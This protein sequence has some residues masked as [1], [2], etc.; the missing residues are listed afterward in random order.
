MDSYETILFDKN[1]IWYVH[2]IPFPTQQN[3]Y[4]IQCKVLRGMHILQ[5]RMQKFLPWFARVAVSFPQ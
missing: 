3:E 1:Q 5:I 4:M 2:S